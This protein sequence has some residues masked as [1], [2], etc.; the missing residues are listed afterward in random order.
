M[1]NKHWYRNSHGKAS[2]EN[3]TIFV[4]NLPERMGPKDLYVLF[5]KFGVVKDVFMPLKRRRKTRSRFG[6]VRYDYRV[7]V[8]IAVQKADKL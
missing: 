1:I 8:E 6:F 2:K 5:T 3:V 7:P 4:D